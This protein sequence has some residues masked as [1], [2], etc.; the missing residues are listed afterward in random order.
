MSTPLTPCPPHTHCCWAG[1]KVTRLQPSQLSWATTTGK[2][3]DLLKVTP[4]VRS[5]T[6]NITLGLRMM[7]RILR[8]FLTSSFPSQS[9]F[10]P[11]EVIKITSL[12]IYSFGIKLSSQLYS[13]FSREGL[14]IKLCQ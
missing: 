6:S 4:L 11:T 9:H 7:L 10:Q 3:R 14:Y 12:E 8:V 2:G 5:R 13:K 1:S